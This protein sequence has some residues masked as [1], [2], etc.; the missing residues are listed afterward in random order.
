MLLQTKF[1]APASNPKSIKRDRLF[2]LFRLGTGKKL[3]IVI[4][5]AGYGKT[6]LVGQWLHDT[7]TF[8][9]WLSLDESD[10]DLRRFWQYVIGAFERIL[11]NVGTEASKLLSKSDFDYLEAVITSLVNALSEQANTETPI[12]LVFDDFH[13]IHD[14]DI[15]RNLV[16][17]IDYLPPNVHVVIT[18]RTEPVFPLSRW[19]VKNFLNEIYAADLA[20]SDDECFRFFN[21][22]MALDISRE[23]AIKI[24]DKT[25]GWVAAMQ[26]AAISRENLQHSAG[27]NQAISNYHGSDKLI[28]DYVLSEILDQQSEEIQSFLLQSSCL[29]RLNSLLCDTVL[30]LENS[31]EILN[32]LEHSNLFIIPL[33][34]SHQWY[35]YHDLFRE[36]LLHRIKQDN[37]KAVL[38]IQKKAI[39]WLLEHDQI[40]ESIDQ[41]VQ[42]QDWEWLKDVL[43]DHGNTLI[44]EGNHLSMLDWINLL[45]H[46]ILE[47]SPQLQMLKI[48]GLFFSNRIDTIPP[49][50]ETLEDT[51]DRRVADSHPDADGAL[52]LNSEIS[53]VRS[54]LARAKADT[55]S[56]SD[57]TKQVL[58]E[59]DHSNM[60]LK[61]VTYYGIGIDCFNKGELADAESALSS[62]IQY[63]KYERKPSAVI[64][65]SGLLTWILYY[66]GELGQSI[67]IYQ[68]TQAW[69]DSYLN[70]PSQPK[71]I[72]CWQNSAMTRAYLERG[73]DV[74]ASSFLNPLLEHLDLGTEPG[75]HVIIQFVRAHILYNSR[76]FEQAIS[77][78]ED[79]QSV[80]ER[81]KE[82]ILYEPPSLTGL[83]AKC[84]LRLG[85]D[86]LA[87]AW[88]NANL[89]NAPEFSNPLNKEE[90]TLAIT[91]ILFETND[92][93]GEQVKR[94]LALLD[95]IQAEIE[96][97]NHIKHLIELLILKTIGLLRQG[98]KES[99]QASLD[100]ALARAQ[101]DHYTALF[102]ENASI[103]APLIKNCIAA[104]VPL[105]YRSE[106]MRKLMQSDSNAPSAH[107]PV[108]AAT[109]QSQSVVDQTNLHPLLEP[110]SQR[111]LE[112]L[113]LINEGH[114]NKEIAAKLFLSP[115]TIKAH[116][117]NIYG[118]LGAKSRTEALARARQHQLI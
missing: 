17:F 40:H 67:E 25:E 36:S 21:E 70:D 117:R 66:K 56:A 79:A 102:Q 84:Q 19:R 92:K 93:S 3:S 22:F 95:S 53:L 5:P 37:P 109:S 52:A 42:L 54:Y 55:K 101:K 38:S 11:P 10:N 51:L 23:E 8:F 89:E 104:N 83:K 94:G 4:A 81:K 28:N 20:F 12:V 118:K 16:F 58:E 24:R 88:A 57:L 43:Q 106:L 62:A 27:I 39:D 71:M 45:P 115:A 7:E 47:D 48:W 60:P 41:L 50:L 75:Q 34:T 90:Q 33:D 97:H 99:A 26:L 14:F 9:T 116:I 86:K 61:S 64:S 73:E 112:V 49:L 46:A 35:R 110:L 96:S 68:G 15:L 100:Q 31:Q 6:T 91:R 32:S 18:S 65:S 72:S 76:K 107:T 113:G 111:E 108:I 63:G 13:H 103:L 105:S 82:S 77:C 80:F 1:F 59:I 114:A 69:L 74:I 29:V 85:L 98:D 78:L 44:H 87:L 30:E 2:N